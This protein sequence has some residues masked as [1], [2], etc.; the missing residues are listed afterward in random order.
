MVIHYL[1][2][3]KKWLTKQNFG[4]N[5]N[6]NTALNKMIREEKKQNEKKKD[7]KDVVSK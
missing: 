7:G 6:R 4:Y 5:P 1:G 3:M 2:D